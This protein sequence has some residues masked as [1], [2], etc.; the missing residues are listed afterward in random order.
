MKKPDYEWTPEVQYD[1]LD[2]ITNELLEKSIKSDFLKL[3]PIYADPLKYSIEVVLIRQKGRV[4]AT[5][6]AFRI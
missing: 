3:F 1:D 4:D 6:R 5:V 2:T